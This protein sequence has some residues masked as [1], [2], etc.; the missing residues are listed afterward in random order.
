[1]SRLD[2]VKAPT[3]R[4]VVTA[5]LG[6]F[7]LAGLASM[8][9]GDGAADMTPGT[10]TTTP[11][12]SDDLAG[13]AALRLD[14]RRCDI[15]TLDV[16]DAMQPVM[17]VRLPID[18]AEH[19]VVLRPHSIRAVGFEVREQLAD[20]SWRSVDPGPVRTV[21][22]EVLDMP[23][24]IVAGALT[25]YG[26]T[27]SIVMPDKTR[28]FV[29]P[30]KG[31]VPGAERTQHAVYNET[32][33]IEPMGTCGTPNI[34]PGDVLDLD[35]GLNATSG[36]G[37][38]GLPLSCTDLA[39]DS[40][41]EFTN[42]WGGTAGV[43]DRIE[44]VINTVNIQYESEVQITHLITT[45]LVRTAEPDPY[46]SSNSSTLLG[47]FRD[48]WLN[49][50]SDIPRDV[51]KLFTGREISGSTIGQ[52]W[53]IGGICTSSAF[54]HS[55][56][57]FNNSFA[58]STDLAAHELG[59]L[60]NGFHCSC[61]SNTMNAS[62]TCANTFSAQTISSIISHRNSR[63]C[64]TPCDGPEDGVTA[65]PFFDDFESGT[66]D[67]TIWTG[68]DGAF[69]DAEGIDEPS[70]GFSLRINGEKEVRSA[71]MNS[72]DALSLTVSYYWQR[73]GN[74][75]SPENG[76]DLIVEYR[77]NIF[78]WELIA[79]HPGA[80]SDTDPYQFES[81]DLPADA[82]HEDFRVRFRGTSPN[83]TGCGGIGCDDFFVDDVAIDII[84]IP[85]GD[86]CQF[87]PPVTSGST[88]ISNVGASTDGPSEPCG[89]FESDVWVRYVT[90]CDGMLTASICDADFDVELGV[91]GLL[92]LSE[93]NLAIDCSTAECGNG[94]IVSVPVN[95]GELYRFR[96]GSANGE[97]GSG[98]LVIECVQSTATGACCF[99]DGNCIV[100][101][102]DECAMMAGAYQ[103]DDTLCDPN[104]CPQPPTGACCFDD[105]SC[106]EGL[107]TACADA[108]GTYQGD[109]SVCDPNPCPQPAL[110][111]ADCAP[112]NGDGTFGNGIV[113]VDDLVAVIN[114][115]G[116]GPGPC[117]I[118]PD[119]GDGTFGNGAV[120]VDDLFEVLNAFGDC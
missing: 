30:L 24:A 75:N 56:N 88:Q 50:Q 43:Q 44:T 73:T 84:E 28:R 36:G 6:L 71:R 101:N 60:W 85:V 33:V 117:D 63:T 93:P 21:R 95:A 77:S 52:A 38:G 31:L 78:T 120:N 13:S 65:L 72:E 3:Y 116:T 4:G 118:A 64:L 79:V 109:D 107:A 18:G 34:G 74:G 8:S 35:A 102:S 59:H 40:D 80:G 12:L 108:G 46:S 87:A 14:L 76:E 49:N 104:P 55:Q 9:I 61:P 99:D 68:I 26:L 66:L 16:P 25:E 47:Q 57:S 54:C 96:I 90:E 7:C 112:A 51:A 100:L 23:G 20:G 62:I 1:M 19:D 29:E 70:G 106:T 32:D 41:V 53:T 39:C 113:N 105:G 5:S 17:L 103:G 10:S 86:T 115:L 37:G 2:F 114:A 111:P 97:W 91:Y 69:V 45:I 58:C 92:C 11:K 89:D 110:C 119:N 94:G 67:N 81:I 48:E 98:T 27:A 83:G 22:G 42:L 15:E 82:F